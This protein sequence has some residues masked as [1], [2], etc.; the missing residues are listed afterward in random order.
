MREAVKCQTALLKGEIVF[1]RSGLVRS[2]AVLGIH[3]DLD[4]I[5]LPLIAQADT[6][7]DT[8]CVLGGVR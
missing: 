5:I 6:L 3:A 4:K 1:N 2:V 8:R 7:V